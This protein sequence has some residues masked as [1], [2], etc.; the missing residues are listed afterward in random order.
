[1]VDTRTVR[2]VAGLSRRSAPRRGMAAMDEV[3]FADMVE[4]TPVTSYVIEYR[5]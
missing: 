1:M 3:D 2:A 5:S 4:H